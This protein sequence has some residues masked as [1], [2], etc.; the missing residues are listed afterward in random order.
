MAA[1]NRVALP[2]HWE[3]NA[4]MSDDGDRVPLDACAL[5]RPPLLILTASVSLLFFLMAVI[6]YGMTI[7]TVSLIES[8]GDTQDPCNVTDSQ[9]LSIFLSNAAEF[10]GYPIS[11]DFMGILLLLTVRS[12]PV[13]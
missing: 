6:Y 10:I 3:L 5:V 13:H 12:C 4:P 1:R 2:E 9:Y 11:M 7:L 8:H